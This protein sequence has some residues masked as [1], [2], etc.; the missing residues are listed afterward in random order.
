MY[1]LP[2]R[3][4]MTELTPWVLAVALYFVAPTSLPLGAYVLLMILFALS[5]DLIVGYAGI[6][7]LGHSAYFGFGAY[8][9]GILAVR[10]SGDPLVGLAAA[11]L[12]A[13]LLGLL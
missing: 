6:V 2:S 9:A 10:F 11:A 1:S 7:T 5:L 13:G 8:T 4:R 3:L 12:G